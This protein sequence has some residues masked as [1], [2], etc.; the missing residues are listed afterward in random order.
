MTVTPE[1]LR[2]KRNSY[3]VI[4][5]S[6][7]REF[8]KNNNMYFFFLEGKDSAYYRPRISAVLAGKNGELSFKNCDGKKNVKDL[9]TAIRLN[10]SLV[11]LQY[12]LFMDR[13]YEHDLDDISM[14]DTF[15]TE[16]YSVEN[17]YTTINSVAAS[18][19]SLFFNDAVHAEDDERCVEKITGIY[20]KVQSEV[21][22]EVALFNYWAWVQRH[23]ERTGK[24]NLD[25]FSLKEFV[26]IDFANCRASSEYTLDA[27]NELAPDR[28]PV[29]AEEI[30]QAKYWFDLKQPQVHFRGKQEAEL[31]VTFL[32]WLANKAQKPEEPFISKKKC[33]GRLS[34]KE[35]LLDLSPYADTPEH[36]SD[37]IMRRRSVWLA[38]LAA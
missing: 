9:A 19:K 21:H 37:C 13:D 34:K 20:S 23:S 8:N 33:A 28:T 30:S 36:L 38:R 35:M 2:G 29:T 15:L 5:Q 27:L 7:I 24:L 4:L 12:L 17:Y 26:D 11:K 1:T 22:R 31:L 25:C 3:S 10:T 18:V 6:L 16:G 32:E 14:E